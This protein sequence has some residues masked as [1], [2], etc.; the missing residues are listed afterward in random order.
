MTVTI[1]SPDCVRV[2]FACNDDGGRTL[3][4]VSGM[5]IGRSELLEFEAVGDVPFA[6]GTRCIWIGGAHRFAT[7]GQAHWIGSMAWD[8]FWMLVSEAERLLVLA[9]RHKWFTLSSGESVLFQQWRQ[10]AFGGLHLR[11]HLTLA[12]REQAGRP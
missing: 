3:D 5:T 8:G 9:H 10:N 1:T 12:S 4:T 6:I 7:L 2:D 11:H